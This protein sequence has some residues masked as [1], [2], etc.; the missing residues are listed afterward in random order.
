MAI[1]GMDVEQVQ[2][3]GNNLKH[4]AEAIAQVIAAVNGLV[5]HSQE[6]WKGHDATEFLGYWEHQHRPALQHV[7]EAV[8]GLGQSAMN[9]ASEQSQVS[10]H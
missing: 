7:M 9:N 6:V 10:G 2:G 3:L 1:V 4:Q 8:S 5:Q